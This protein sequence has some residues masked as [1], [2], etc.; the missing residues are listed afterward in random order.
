VRVRPPVSRDGLSGARATS[1]DVPELERRHRHDNR[2]QQTAAPSPPT[3]QAETPEP[4]EPHRRPDPATPRRRSHYS[5][6]PRP[7]CLPF[8]SPR[9]FTPS[10]HSPHPRLPDLPYSDPL[11]AAPP[12]ATPA[13]RLGWP[14][15][16]YLAGRG[17]GVRRK[18]ADPPFSKAQAGRQGNT[19]RRGGGLL[20]PWRKPIE[21]N[22][23][24]E[25]HGGKHAWQSPQARSG[26]SG[27][28]LPS[29]DLPCSRFHAVGE[30]SL[31]SGVRESAAFVEKQRSRSVLLLVVLSTSPTPVMDLPRFGRH[32]C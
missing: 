8:A 18:A 5:S 14:V 27:L 12:E 3:P 13:S 24:S 30:S 22:R 32:G 6:L 23:W 7:T 20:R 4:L 17:R 11:A 29:S 26:G 19:L 2:Q 28:L 21:R 15:Q 10:A 16:V 1:G 9:L 25:T 31:E